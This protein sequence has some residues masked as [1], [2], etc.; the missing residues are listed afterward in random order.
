MRSM[1]VFLVATALGAVAA[2]GSWGATWRVELDGSGDFTDI[3]PAVDAAAAGDT[4]LIGPGRF[5]TFHPCVAPA[6]TEETIVWVTKDDLMFI[7]SG[8][9]VTIIGPTTY[10]GAPGEDPKGFTQF[11]D[12]SGSIN[13]LTI[14]NI[15]I[16][17]H[18]E[19]TLNMEGCRI[20]ALSGSSVGLFVWPSGGMAKNCRFEM[21]SGGRGCIV[22]TAGFDFAIEDCE[23]S[24]PG[25]AIDVLGGS[26]NTNIRRCEIREPRYGVIIE[27][28]ST[29]SVVDCQITDAGEYAVLVT[30][31]SALNLERT[32][33]RGAATGIVADSGSTL[34]GNNVIVENTTREALL[35]CCNTL[36]TFNTC[37]ILPASGWA[38]RC[39]GSWS[40]VHTLDLTGNYWGTTDAV[41]I[42]ASIWDGNDEPAIQC[43][44]QFD[45][46]ADGPVPTETTTWG[47]LKALFR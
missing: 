2:T 29:G 40:N 18:W 6:W 1:R 8:Q 31:A 30:T 22:A 7:G 28:G 24:G 25:Y 19:G 37:H 5:D 13:N 11:P 15:E 47:D 4:I 36:V 39:Y 9:D 12:F 23:F 17:V 42:A 20:R 33:V 45:P 21:S 44:M 27:Q 35:F 46:F 10:Y 43:T 14:E 34:T 16:G 32:T 38:V 26:H 41:V 3:Q